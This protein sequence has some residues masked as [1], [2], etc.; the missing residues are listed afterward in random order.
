MA[1][2]Q[3]RI[4]MKLTTEAMRGWAGALAAEV[5]Q[6]TG[7]TVKNAFGM[8][9]VY[10]NG[11]VFAALPKTRALYEEDVILIKFNA[12]SSSLA[13]RIADEPRLAGT[14]ERHMTREHKTAGQSKKWRI[15]RIRKDADVHAAIEW[16]AEAY[17]AARRKPGRK[18]SSS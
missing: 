10:R 6:W 7:V 4:N 12:E 8:T 18:P 15:L 11:V 13:K 3:Q 2:K 9:M 1:D 16:M 14:M 5:A 17:G